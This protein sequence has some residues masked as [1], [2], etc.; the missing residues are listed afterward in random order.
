MTGL[1]GSW[2]LTGQVAV[3]TGAARGIGRE[4][5]R[6]LVARGA[7]VVA[8]DIRA[9]VGALASEHVATLQADAGDEKAVR[10][11]MAL[12]LDR[13]GRLD[14]LVSNAGRTR[15]T[16]LGETTVA[17][18]DAILATNAR[19]TFLHLREAGQIMA[20]QG[21]GA[22]VAI[23]SVVS[24]VGMRET[25]AYSA[26]KGA[27]AQLVKTAALEL[28]ASG[29]RVNAVAPGVVA[30]DILEGIVADSRET[31]ASYGHVHALGR[32]AQPAE[33]AEVIAFLGSRAASFVTG[34]LVMADGGY[35]AM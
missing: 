35:T 13:F 32:V 11:T 4:T 9:D 31:L 3:V 8:T 14:I 34:A 6:L 17:D 30:T 7:Q 1:P 20:A 22:I 18:W 33:I 21:S 29:V 16:P 5:V 2:N 25:A 15:N 10:A 23:A 26:S 27:I 12:A 28:G 19:G 24:A